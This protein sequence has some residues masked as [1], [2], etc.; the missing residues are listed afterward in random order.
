M[1]FDAAVT[2]GRSESVSGGRTTG[3]VRS[4]TDRDLGG[5]V[6][7]LAEVHE[8]D[9]YPVNWPDRPDARLSPPSLLAAWVV[10]VDGRIA[11]HI[12]LS[13]SGA[14][15]AAPALWSARAGVGVDETAVINRLF[16]APW[17]RG[18]GPGATLMAQ[19]VSE[20]RHRVPHPVLDV[21]AS[22]TAAAALHER[23]QPRRP[24][25]SLHDWYRS[26]RRPGH[27]PGGVEASWSR[28]EDPRHPPPPQGGGGAGRWRNPAAP[29]AHRSERPYSSR[30]PHALVM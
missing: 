2:S 16:V 29:A 26:G 4:R 1:C 12:G 24:R 13:P 23:P 15:D 21:V 8:R 5:C 22:D 20:A 19:A 6:R 9:G 11:G 3:E 30:S 17:A 10:E 18:L 27:R 28:P 25:G 14:D 7:V